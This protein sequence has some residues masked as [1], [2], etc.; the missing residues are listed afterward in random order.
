M[1]DLLFGLRVGAIGM[2]LVFALLGL[3]WIALSLLARLD[4]ALAVRQEGARA[5]GRGAA[6]VPAAVV[7]GAADLEPEALAA[8]ALAVGAHA[9]LLRRQAAPA[10]RSTQPGSQIYASRWLAAGRTRQTR[11]FARR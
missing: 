5:A 1:E 10:Q 4:A 8:I 11:S 2:G 3:L 7:D 9:A 6:P